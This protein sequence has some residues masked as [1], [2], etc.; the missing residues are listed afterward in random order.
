MQKVMKKIKQIVTSR[1]INN[2]LNTPNKFSITSI[3]DLLLNS[4]ILIFREGN[5]N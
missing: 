3:Y 1:Q 4:Q 2:A 5:T